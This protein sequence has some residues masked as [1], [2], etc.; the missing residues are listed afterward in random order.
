MGLKISFSILAIVSMAI[1]A[2][3]FLSAREQVSR[4][5]GR[6]VVLSAKGESVEIR[7]SSGERVIRIEG[8]PQAHQSDIPDLKVYADLK[9]QKI[10]LSNMDLGLLDRHFHIVIGEKKF[11]ILNFKFVPGPGKGTRDPHDIRYEDGE[12]LHGS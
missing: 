3:L 11:W 8:I 12:D 1:I 9:V 2:W 5:G 7:Q 6:H 4:D 10:S